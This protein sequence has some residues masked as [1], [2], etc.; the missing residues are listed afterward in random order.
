MQAL[1]AVNCIIYGKHENRCFLLCKKS[2]K[3]E[4]K[5]STDFCYAL[6][7]HEVF[8]D[9]Q[10]MVMTGVGFAIQTIAN[11]A[12]AALSKILENNSGFTW[13]T[14]INSLFKCF[15]CLKHLLS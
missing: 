6:N 5:A 12:Q 11:H 3:E 7:V 14:F 2:R 9:W 4:K 15:S 13:V 1:S 8:Q 10:T